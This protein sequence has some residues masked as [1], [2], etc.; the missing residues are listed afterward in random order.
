MQDFPVNPDH[1]EQPVRLEDD[2]GTT[3]QLH[4]KRIDVRVVRRLLNDATATVILGER[5]G[6]HPRPVGAAER[7]ALW[8][9]IKGDY[10]GP[11]GD[12]ATGRFL[13]HEFRADTGRRMLFIEEHC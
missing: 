11:G 12:W 10:L 2:N 8:G 4:R 3:W 5:G 13:A 1:L 6:T 7:A 9:K